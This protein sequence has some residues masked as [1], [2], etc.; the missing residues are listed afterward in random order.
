[1][2]PVAFDYER[3]GELGAALELLS[4]GAG[5]A[6]EFKAMVDDYVARRYGLGGG[7]A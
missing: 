4:R 5:I 3:P 6:N 2:K 7:A 1:M